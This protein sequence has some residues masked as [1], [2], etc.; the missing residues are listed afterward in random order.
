MK[1]SNLKNHWFS[2]GKTY[3]LQNRRVLKLV[4]KVVEN[5][6]KNDAKIHLKTIQNSIQNRHAEKYRKSMDGLQKKVEN[7]ARRRPKSPQNPCK[8]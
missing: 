3:I 4:E 7:G 5:V 2:L 8:N 1:P 6:I